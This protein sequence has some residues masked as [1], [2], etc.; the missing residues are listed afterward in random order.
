MGEPTN[1]LAHYIRDLG[2]KWIQRR[3]KEIEPIWN[4]NFAMIKGL[5]PFPE[6]KKGDGGETEGQEWRSDIVVNITRVKIFAVLGMLL[7]ILLPDSKVPFSL[8]LAPG[9]LDD[10][11]EED[12][13]YEEDARDRMVR[14]IKQQLAERKA[15]RQIK[16]KLMSLLY[17][18]ICWSKYNMRMIKSKGHRKINQAPEGIAY[19][20]GAGRDTDRWE[21]FSTE[22]AVPGH[23][24]RS[25]WSIFWDLEVELDK[26]D[27]GKGVFEREMISLYDLRQKKGKEHYIDA[28]IEKV[29]GEWEKE[30]ISVDTTSL[31]PGERE[32]AERVRNIDN[33][34][35]WIRV[36][37][38]LIDQFEDEELGWLKKGEE[39]VVSLDYQEDETGEDVFILAETADDE[40][41]RYK[42]RNDGT[43]LHHPGVWE[44]NLDDPANPAR[45]IPCNM[46]DVQKITTG[47]YRAF[48]DNKRLSGDVILAVMKN[49]LQDPSQL[50]GGIKPGLILDLDPLA[51]SAKDAVEQVVIQDT[52]ESYVSGIGLAERLTDVLSMLPELIQGL[53][54]LKR[55]SDTAYE[56]SQLMENAGKYVGQGIRNFD[57]QQ[58]E[59]EI[60]D[61]YA[62]NMA[63]PD[64]DS[65]AKGNFLCLPGGFINF[66][67]KVLTVQQLEK[68]IA[69]ALS[70]ELLAG[71][72][73]FKEVM[74]E[75]FRNVGFDAE[76]FLK[77]EEEKKQESEQQAK[78]Q[79]EARAKAIQ[80]LAAQT[81]IETEGKIAIE[82]EKNRGKLEVERLKAEAGAEKDEDEFQRDMVKQIGADAQEEKMTDKAE[83]AQKG[84]EKAK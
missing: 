70:H 66:K 57:D 69:I 23:D 63:D 25:A 26:L 81:Q 22:K 45:S 29:I 37:L 84:K 46:V 8:D 16:R 64:F 3:K 15:D 38:K 83:K 75:L 62:F 20:E 80:D 14:A 77:S 34:E 35:Y 54:M 82:E 41:I 52:G 56:T 6:F 51:K 30:A 31:K 44:E 4:R 72:V 43:L 18:G 58:I 1:S 59:P 42:R 53:G 19:Q 21:P 5:D 49:A 12:R 7:D 48:I 65:K 17:Y 33:R 78:I 73:K 67:N 11:S 47:L 32:I 68:L 28:A 55:K 10:L 71:E 39:A 74:K 61:I 50:D 40:V 9:D 27:T 13:E 76:K 2:H 79:E 60:E 24:F 36:P